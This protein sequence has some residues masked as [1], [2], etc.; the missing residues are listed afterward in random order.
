MSTLLLRKGRGGALLTPTAPSSETAD[1]WLVRLRWAAIAGMLATIVIAKRIVVD[2]DIYPLL[3]ILGGIL[4]L[5]LLWVL[6]VRRPHRWAVTSL[7]VT[8][9]VL[10]I[11]ALL[12]FSGGTQNPF[13]AFVTFQI[14]LAGLLCPGR[15][16]VFIAALTLAAVAVL[17]FADPL[18][19][20]SALIGPAEVQRIGRIVSLATLSAFLGFFVFVYV[21]RLEEL[22]TESA[23]NEK[24]AVLG[25]LVGTM[26]HELNTP[27]A[28]ILLA[29]KDLVDVGRELGSGEASRLSQT[30]VEEAERASDLIG[31][32]RGHIRPDQIGEAIDVSA[33]VSD[34]ATRELDRLGYQGE[35]SVEGAGAIRS[36]VIK[37]GLTRIVSNVLANAVQAVA[38]A[39]RPRIGVVVTAR[40]AKIEISV[41][42]NGRGIDPSLRLGEPFQ[43]TKLEGMGLGL[44]LSSV[45]AD[46][47]EGALQIESVEGG[48]TRVAL[49][50][51]R[52]E[53][54]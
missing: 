52:K 27:L 11:T 7:Q 51:P 34:L 12:W 8:L 41:R 17:S 35:R 50:L 38:G 23:R 36:V 6:L 16:T 10:G 2:L 40:R 48:G 25:S 4:A 20:D 53:R 47:M 9:D 43:T 24:L 19:L 22:R 45:L 5:N 26:S 13:A 1:R 39:E 15:T 14:V 21:Q 37:A 42:D 33:F 44:Y 32:M 30:I 54:H 49:I 29:G 18:P 3:A 28:T 31:L 46:R